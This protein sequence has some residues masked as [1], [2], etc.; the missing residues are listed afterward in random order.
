MFK[1][2]PKSFSIEKRFNTWISKNLSLEKLFD[3]GCW[4]SFSLEKDFDISIKSFLHEKLFESHVLKCFS[5]EKLFAKCLNICLYIKTY[6]CDTL[7]KVFRP[8]A[9]RAINKNVLS[10][11]RNYETRNYE[12]RNVLSSRWLWQWKLWD[13]SGWQSNIHNRLNVRCGTNYVKYDTNHCDHIKYTMNESHQIQ[14][15]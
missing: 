10:L 14:Y 12:T 15:M 7:N 6:L 2:K 9:A 1:Q 11:I 13:C 4:R 8:K 5:S 3:K